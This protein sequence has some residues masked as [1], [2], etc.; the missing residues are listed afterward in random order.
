MTHNAEVQS[1]PHARGRSS[2][3]KTTRLVLSTIIF[4]IT[5]NIVKL[6]I[7]V[8]SAPCAQNPHTGE[9]QTWQVYDYLMNQK[10]S[11]IVWFS[12]KSH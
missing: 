1:V 11:K 5:V 10:E 12:E 2:L 7:H 6:Q 4:N 9:D 3:G 8:L